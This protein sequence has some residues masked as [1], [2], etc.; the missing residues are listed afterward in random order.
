MENTSWKALLGFKWFSGSPDLHIYDVTT[1][2]IF[3]KAKPASTY[4]SLRQAL[5]FLSSLLIPH[6]LALIVCNAL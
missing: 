3:D 4:V 5:S 1:T 6:L 2:T